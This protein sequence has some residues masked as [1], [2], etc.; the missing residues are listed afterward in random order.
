[1][2]GGFGG[3]D[4]VLADPPWRFSSNSKAK[5]GR[6]AMRH[7]ACMKDAEIAAIPIPAAKD[8]LLFMWTTAPMLARSMPILDAWGF[9]YVS[10]LVWLKSRIGTGFWVRNRHEIVLIAKRGKFPCPRPAPFSDS[11]I[12][13]PSREHSRKPDQTYARIERR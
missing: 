3:Y 5:P 2:D 12:A 13:S 6:N 8:S 11:V 9:T 1:M 7:Y 4:I 10:H